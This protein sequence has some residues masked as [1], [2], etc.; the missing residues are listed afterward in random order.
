MGHHLGSADKY[1]FAT[2]SKIQFYLRGATVED[3]KLIFDLSNENLVRK[4]SINPNSIAWEDHLKWLPQ[5]INYK[6]WFYLLAFSIENSFIGQIRIDVSDEGAIIGISITPEFRGKGLSTDLLIHSAQL[7]F[8]SYPQ[9]NFV[10]AK[11]N[12]NNKASINTFL[13]AGYVYSH[14][15][16]INNNEFLVFKLVR[17]N[18][19]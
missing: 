17:K 12:K 1:H 18:E 10:T 9:V 4:N 5:K 15:E 3:A 14:K 8:A 13:K 19:N 7:F 16:S 2:K 6:N 11:I